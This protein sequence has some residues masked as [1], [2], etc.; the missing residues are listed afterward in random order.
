MLS[1]DLAFVAPDDKAVLE[2]FRSSGPQPHSLGIAFDINRKYNPQ[3]NAG[4]QPGEIGSVSELI[5]IFEHFGFM[6]GGERN[7]AHFQLSHFSGAKD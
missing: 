2:L 4:A 5:L 7:A 1:W 6:W 3:D